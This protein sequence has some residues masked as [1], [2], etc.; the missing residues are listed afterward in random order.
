MIPPQEVS[1]ITQCE[2]LNNEDKEEMLLARYYGLP[3]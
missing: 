3:E 2:I 1:V